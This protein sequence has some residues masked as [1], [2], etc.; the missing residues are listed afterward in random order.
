MVMP[1]LC[2]GY[3]MVMPWLWLVHRLT[4]G[5]KWSHYPKT[6]PNSLS[7]GLTG[8]DCTAVAEDL[9]LPTAHPTNFFA[10]PQLD[11]KVLDPK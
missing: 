4:N 1:W 7:A 11:E 9:S 6:L 5:Y 3:A 8:A 10:G 2:H